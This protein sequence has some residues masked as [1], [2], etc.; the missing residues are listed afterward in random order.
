VEVTF[1]RKRK[2]S[3]AYDVPKY[4]RYLAVSGFF[5]DKGRAEKHRNRQD[6]RQGRLLRG[7]RAGPIKRKIN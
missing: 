3:L 6:D 7:N 2:V 5:P 4:A 1:E